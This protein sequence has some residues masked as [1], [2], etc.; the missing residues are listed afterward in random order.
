VTLRRVVDESGR[1]RVNNSLMAVAAVDC[2][3]N[4]VRAVATELGLDA[5]CFLRRDVPQPASL[6]KVGCIEQQLAPACHRAEAQRNDAV[7]AP[8]YLKLRRVPIRQG[9]AGIQRGAHVI[10][11]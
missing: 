10:T 7:F 4:A 5:P 2:A 8:L 9:V 6:V 1:F 3:D 11:R